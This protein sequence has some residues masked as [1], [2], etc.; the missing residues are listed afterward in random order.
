MSWDK[1]SEVYTHP[2]ILQRLLTTNHPPTPEDIGPLEESRKSVRHSLLQVQKEIRVLQQ[3]LTALKRKQAQLLVADDELGGVLSPIRRLPREILA[4]ILCLVPERKPSRNEAYHGDNAVQFHHAF[5][6]RP[7]YGLPWTLSY[8]CQEWRTV[9]ISLCP[10]LWTNLHIESHPEPLK[11]PVALLREALKRSG[12][13]PLCIKFRLWYMDDNMPTVVHAIAVEL[14]QAIVSCCN[15]WRVVEM[16]IRQHMWP[17]L[18]P[19]LACGPLPF[20]EALRIDCYSYSSNSDTS[21]TAYRPVTLDSHPYL[22]KILSSSP[23]LRDF[24]LSY[25]AENDGL[26]SRVTTTP[27]RCESMRTLTA[28]D[29]A[30]FES[31]ELPGLEDLNVSTLQENVPDFHGPD[32][33]LSVLHALVL[34][35]RPPLVHLSLTDT[36]IDD[37][38][39]RIIALIPALA[40]LKF[41]FQQWLEEFDVVFQEFMMRFGQV[42][43]STGAHCLV[44]GLQLFSVE[45]HNASQHVDFVNQRLVSVVMSRWTSPQ[46]ALKTILIEADVEFRLSSADVRNLKVCQAQG[47]EIYIVGEYA[48]GCIKYV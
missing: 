35:S 26:P 46:R 45:I 8:V 20:L 37:N 36:I 25:D 6:T 18:H 42:V 15:R 14:F 27:I 13:R 33:M 39:L 19:I 30:I 5:D 1:S 7:G 28:F 34:R 2:D 29:V 3:S 16:D 4:E 11:N 21:P 38:L 17:A 47:L 40:T 23:K 9:L 44:P 12:N 31:L 10:Q 41:Q 24:S 43:P 32:E 48:D 22:H